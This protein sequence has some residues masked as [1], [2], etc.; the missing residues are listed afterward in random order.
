MKS[1]FVLLIVLMLGPGGCKAGEDGPA[2]PDPTTPSEPQEPQDPTPPPEG[3]GYVDWADPSPWI[4]N[5]TPA[6]IAHLREVAAAGRAQGRIPGR[7]GQ[8]G[9]SISESSAYIRT[10]AIY[11]VSNNE[12]GHDY[13]PVLEWMGN[14]PQCFYALKGK[15]PA[16]GNGAGLKLHQVLALGHP[17]GPVEEGHEGEPGDYSW[18]VVMY[19]TNDIDPWD[20]SPEWWR[21]KWREYVSQLLALGVVPALSTIPPEDR[22]RDDGLV[23]AANEVIVEIAEEFDI[24]WIDFHG[25][26]LHWQPQDWQGTLLADDGTHPDGHG[27]DFSHDGLTR[28]D[29]YAARNKLTLDFGELMAKQ[30]FAALDE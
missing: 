2:A 10:V 20:W 13:G 25:W 15:G 27:V 23:E 11:G 30:V 26:I 7:L 3:G 24:P 29:G 4:H 28:D 6:V 8:L 1:L 19:G 17:T 14:G 5:L 22:H 12:T 16:W 18:A 21:P 9:D